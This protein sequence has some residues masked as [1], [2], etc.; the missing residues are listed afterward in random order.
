M[1]ACM[2]WVHT[3]KQVNIL[4]SLRLI[5][6]TVKRHIRALIAFEQS[7]NSYAALLVLIILGKFPEEIR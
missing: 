2:P 1:H 6:D 4:F 5:H 3:P 7:D